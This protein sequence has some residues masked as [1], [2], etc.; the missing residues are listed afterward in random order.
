[1][2]HEHYRRVFLRRSFFFRTISRYSF[3][4]YSETENLQ[5]E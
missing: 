3:S 1:M 4:R 2:T 5:I